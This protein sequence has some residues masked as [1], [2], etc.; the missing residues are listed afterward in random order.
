MTIPIY[1]RLVEDVKVALKNGE[2]KRLGALR[3]MLADLKKIEID[4]R[5][6]VDDARAIQALDKMMKQ[7][8]DSHSQFFEAQ[9]H[10]L[11]EQE[12]YEMEIISEY[13]PEPLSVQEMEKIV[14]EAIKQ[15]A[16]A[17]PK[18]MGA[19]MAIIQKQSE[20]GLN[21]KEVA[22]LVKSKLS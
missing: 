6:E 13:L 11:A 22:A 12:A 20:G 7:R 14:S 16:A 17:S 10:D 5:Q 18:D 1:H 8:R 3:L 15:S 19:V 9:R 21:M 4:E 2:K